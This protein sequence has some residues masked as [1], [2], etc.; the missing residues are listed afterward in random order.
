MFKKLKPIIKYIAL[1]A[2][3]I[4]VMLATGLTPPQVNITSNGRHM[5]ISTQ[6]WN[7]EAQAAGSITTLGT[8]NDYKVAGT[9]WIALTGLSLSA[10]DYVIVCE[11]GDSATSAVSAVHNPAVVDQQTT[12]G[13]FSN[14]DVYGSRIIGQTFFASS[15]YTL[16]IIAPYMEVEGTPTGNLVVSVYNV[17]GEHKPSG[18]ALTTGSILANSVTTAD[19]YPVSLTPYALTASVEYAFV[20]SCPDCDIDNNVHTGVSSSN[21]ISGVYVISTDGGSNWSVYTSFDM[22]F[23]TYDAE[24]SVSLNDDVTGDNAGNVVGKIWS[25][26]ISQTYSDYYIAITNTSNAK[27]MT[28]YKVSGLE[29]SALDKYN[30]GTG[31]GTTINSGST[32]VLSQADEVGIG[33]MAMEEEADE[34]GTPTTGANYVEG[35]D[36]T[37]TADGGGAKSITVYAVAEVLSVTTAQEAEMTSTGGNDWAGCVATY[38]VASGVTLDISNTPSSEN[39]GTVADSSTYYAFGSAP[40]NPVQDGE[41]TF[42]VTNNGDQCDLDMK[43]S[44]FTGGTSWNIVSGSPGANEVR[45]TAYYSGQNPAS[46]L[47]LANTDAEFYDALAGSATLKW[48]FKFET[49]TLADE[50][51]QHS[52]TL[53]ITATV[54]D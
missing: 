44:D 41:C 7:I 21:K 2:L 9:T 47:V 27:A 54:E 28:A 26:Q 31:S 10:D 29:A 34:L 35:N 16:S 51:N 15:S 45:V 20:V 17:D 33:L 43:I 6:S 25:G 1:P 50:P 48:D 39:L 12:D 46:G 38:T 52:A 3:V 30:S 32:G 23:K 11:A 13:N 37:D 4:A 53:T 36:Q 19:Y 8:N 14:E 42:T 5:S 49:G 40:S 22:A 18:G 24:V